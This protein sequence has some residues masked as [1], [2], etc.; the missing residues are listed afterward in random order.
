MIK[1]CVFFQKPACYKDG[2]GSRHS[3]KLFCLKCPVRTIKKF[4]KK[5][6]FLTFKFLW[7]P[8]VNAAARDVVGTHWH[9][10]KHGWVLDNN[11]VAAFPVFSTRTHCFQIKLSQVTFI[12]SFLILLPINRHR[13]TT[14]KQ[15]PYL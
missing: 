11:T 8:F 3:K 14:T 1:L 12:V 7:C 6:G 9:L 4:V 10:C 2:T 5:C 13:L 15:L